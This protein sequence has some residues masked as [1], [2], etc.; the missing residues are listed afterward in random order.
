MH[1]AADEAV[2][3]RLPACKGHDVQAGARGV[4]GEGAQQS[5]RP[6]RLT[7]RPRREGG[8]S[9][10]PSSGCVRRLEPR[11]THHPR[12]GASRR[13]PEQCD[14]PR[15]RSACRGTVPLEQTIGGH[16]SPAST[17][18]QVWRSRSGRR[19]AGGDLLGPCPDRLV[20][21]GK[22]SSV[23][24]GGYTLRTRQSVVSIRQRSGLGAGGGL[25]QLAPHRAFPPEAEP[26]WRWE[27]PAQV[28]PCSPRPWRSIVAVAGPAAP[29]RVTRGR[30][31][32]AR[33]GAP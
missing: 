16:S 11:A 13:A 24:P 20:R 14:L 19:L 30:G 33:Q 15:G 7:A 18:H 27:R 8:P 6:A 4:R 26:G 17:G 10:L 32:G 1:V 5:E 28:G 3:A 31:R 12:P 21:V 25:R 2:L 9:R 29:A 22:D 23:C